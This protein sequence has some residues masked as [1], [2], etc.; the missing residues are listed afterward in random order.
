MI[1]VDQPQA[2]VYAAYGAG[3]G[4]HKVWLWKCGAPPG[5]ADVYSVTRLSR[6]VPS[7]SPAA[8]PALFT[9]HQLYRQWRIVVTT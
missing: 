4:P 5:K 8:L 9:N 7:S 3:L 2:T 6:F 1:D